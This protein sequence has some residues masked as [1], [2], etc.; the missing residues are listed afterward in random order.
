[1][2]RAARG[3]SRRGREWPAPATAVR[4]Q[5]TTTCARFRPAGRG[6][7][8]PHQHSQHRHARLAAPTTALSSCNL[9]FRVSSCPKTNRLRCHTP[10]LPRGVLDT[11]TGSASNCAPG[12][13]CRH[14]AKSRRTVDMSR[15]GM[16]RD[17]IQGTRAL[18]AGLWAG[19]APRAGGAGVAQ[20]G[21]PR[22]GYRLDSG[23]GWSSVRPA[24]SSRAAVCGACPTPGAWPSS[25]MVAA[26]A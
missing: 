4:P 20:A 16:G 2:P 12:A 18:T 3:R 1:M 8:S 9:A 21:V 25:A 15:R 5:N 6:P 23:R 19:G 13:V 24:G 10:S 22:R 17:R 14:S 26:T 7:A 11:P